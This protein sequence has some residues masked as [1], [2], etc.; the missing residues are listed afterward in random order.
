MD[1]EIKTGKAQVEELKASI[2]QEGSFIMAHTTKID[3][4][5]AE[6]AVDQADLKAATE[7]RSHEVKDFAAE[8]RDLVETVDTLHRASQIIEREMQG[9]ASMLQLKQASSIT[10][11]LS[12]MVQASMIGTLANR[13]EGHS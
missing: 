7:I 3:E 2:A 11:A 1:F 6:L 12:V 10:Q 13:E 4:L 9:G 5:A 8:E